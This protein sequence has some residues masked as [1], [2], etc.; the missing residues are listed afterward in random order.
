MMVVLFTFHPRRHPLTIFIAPSGGDFWPFNPYQQ[1]VLIVCLEVE[2]RCLSNPQFDMFY[3]P[4]V[5]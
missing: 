3:K 1:N 4:P 2:E 5:H